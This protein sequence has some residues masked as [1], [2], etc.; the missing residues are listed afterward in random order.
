MDLLGHLQMMNKWKIKMGMVPEDEG[1]AVW[2]W[3]K[4]VEVGRGSYVSLWW[5]SLS[6][7]EGDRK[8]LN[9]WWGVGVGAWGRVAVERVLSCTVIWECC[10]FAVSWL[11]ATAV[12]KA[13]LKDS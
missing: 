4:F 2:D 7:V 11:C 8:R 13:E 3:D 10:H 9:G 6:E 12:C 1:K 5:L